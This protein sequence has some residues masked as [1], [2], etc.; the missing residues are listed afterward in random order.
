M[1][2]DAN[3]TPTG[4]NNSRG[5]WFDVAEDEG[6][7]LY[8][9]LRQITAIRFSPAYVRGGGSHDSAI[10]FSGHCPVA[11]FGR[12]DA[13]RLQRILDDQRAQDG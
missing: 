10:L 1:H 6:G 3:E 11:E 5:L 8:V 7:V 9:N 4:N 12:G 13:S 2:T